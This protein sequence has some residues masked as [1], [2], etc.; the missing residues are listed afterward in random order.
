MNERKTAAGAAAL[1]KA[2]GELRTF[3]D[4]H[5]PSW[6]PLWA[7]QLSAVRLFLEP[8]PHTRADVFNLADQ[9]ARA[10]GGA[11][12]GAFDEVGL[13]RNDRDEQGRINAVLQA[14]KDAIWDAIAQLREAA[15][16]GESNQLA[17][18]RHLTTLE[19]DSMAASDDAMAS[20]IRALLDA[21][22]IEPTALRGL[23]TDWLEHLGDAEGRAVGMA[24][25]RALLAELKP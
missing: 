20:R 2:I 3:V 4:V 12:M 18:R 1:A 16:E 8:A 23:T 11:H 21:D 24:A 15:N 9:V 22:A 6:A 7:A 13:A 14:L 25:I 19:T 5:L 17:I 10:F